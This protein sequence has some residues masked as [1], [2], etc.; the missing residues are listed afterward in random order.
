MM[1]RT[2]I[3][4]EDSREAMAK[5]MK[6]CGEDAVILST[7]KVPGGVEIIAG[8]EPKLSMFRS[9]GLGQNF[10]MDMDDENDDET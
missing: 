6:E 5:V 9:L 1:Q 2:K 8:H 7:R 10:D 3:V 4:A